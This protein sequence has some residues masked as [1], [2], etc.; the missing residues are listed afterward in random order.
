MRDFHKL[1]FF[2]G[3]GNLKQIAFPSRPVIAGRRRFARV[4]EGKYA[5]VAGAMIQREREV[6]P[7][8]AEEA[9]VKHEGDFRGKLVA[10][11]EEEFP[12]FQ[13][14]FQ[15]VSSAFAE[16]IIPVAKSEVGA[17]ELELTQTERY[18]R[19]VAEN[20]AG[21]YTSSSIGQ[22]VKVTAAAEEG[23]EIAAVEERLQKWSDRR[24]QDVGFGQ[25]IDCENAFAIFVYFAAGFRIV[26]V[27]VGKNCS[28]CNAL[29]GR[30]IS[31]G[32][33]FQSKGDVLEPDGVEGKKLTVTRLIRH[34]RLHASCDCTT[35]ATAF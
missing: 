14:R 23:E 7:G 16:E 8:F 3:G 22:M 27:T 31:E 18:V 13:T 21:A 5:E 11:Y 24:A 2:F 32:Q 35:R 12:F 25:S 10:W 6:I 30:T 33:S 19:D 1:N 34:P 17:E 20:Q 9:F 28:F 26:W 15:G 29:S 4:F